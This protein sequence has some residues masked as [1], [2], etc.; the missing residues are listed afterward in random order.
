MVG[1]SPDWCCIRK[2]KGLRS[3]DG[4]TINAQNH[5]WRLL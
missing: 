3:S 5:N 2:N 4:G 1:N